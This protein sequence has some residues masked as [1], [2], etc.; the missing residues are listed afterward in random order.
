MENIRWALITSIA[1]IAWGSTYYVTHH[2]LPADHPL[3]GSV[4]RALPAGVL[5]LV[6]RRKRPR[7]QWWWR[8][9]VL[10]TLNMGAFFALVY[11][12]AQ[13]LPTSL[14]STIMATSPV[15][16]IAL[17]WPLLGERPRGRAV[18]GAVTGILGV[19]LMLASGVDSVDPLG[20]VVSVAAMAMSAFGHLLTKRWG[21]GTDLLSVTSWQLIAG[22]AVLVVPALVVEG[23]P[24][25]LT[26]TALLGFAFVSVVATA[27]AFVVWFTG[28]RH[29]EAGTVGL[30]GL[31][32]PVTGVMLGLLLAGESLVGHQVLG[33][34][35]VLSGVLLG[36]TTRTPMSRTP[37]R[38]RP[39][40]QAPPRAPGEVEETDMEREELNEVLHKPI[41]QE[42][43]ASSIPARLAYIGVD[44]D[45]RVV[46]I[47]FL[48]DGARIVMGT[49]PKS[50]KVRALRHNP[51]VSL[52][53]DTAGQYPPHVLLIR[54]TASVELV[55]GVPYEY[56]EASRKLVPAGEFAAWE[57]GVRAL[58]EQ[59]VLIRI[60][61][62]WAKLLD[63]ETTIPQAV[64]DL[65][66]AHQG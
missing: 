21:A 3:W 7:G 5:L 36:Q 47:A 50:A 33:L 45:P 2:F 59:M 55:D 60:E 61:P 32:N 66:R 64:E 9:L 62:R 16:M 43:L 54:G 10:G 12:A 29:L 35:L 15:A 63:F 6:L 57:A 14:A 23:A 39:A 34:V 52:T 31:L 30:I 38:L 58:Y 26:G 22:G 27:I 65:V 56:V 1:P 13:L 53:I 19:V 11:L 51:N 24:P 42:L 40:R 48:W 17:A 18:L 49:V 28:L 44:G 37:R 25:P 8:S 20:V 4:L 41:A 46:P